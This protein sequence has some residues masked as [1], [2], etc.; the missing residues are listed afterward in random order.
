MHAKPLKTWH[1]ATGNGHHITRYTLC[2]KDTSLLQTIY[3]RPVVS[4]IQRFYCS[5]HLLQQECLESKSNENEVHCIYSQKFGRYLN[6]AV[7]SVP[8]QPPNQY[9]PKFLTIAH[10]NTILWYLRTCT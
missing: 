8:I 1:A 5:W 3:R 2:T 4:V 10:I 7:N 9:P 6:L